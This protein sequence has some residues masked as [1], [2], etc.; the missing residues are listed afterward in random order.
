MFQE[1]SG[2]VQKHY[3]YLTRY[4][5]IQMSYSNLNAS[6]KLELTYRRKYWK[7]VLKITEIDSVFLCECCKFMRSLK[8]KDKKQNPTRP[9]YKPDHFRRRKD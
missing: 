3:N 9:P 6:K 1:S 2:G 7:M 8:V 5:A 4:A